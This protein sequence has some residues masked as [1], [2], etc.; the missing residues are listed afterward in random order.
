M[1]IHAAMEMPEDKPAYSVLYEQ[2]TWTWDE[3][4]S[5]HLEFYPNGRGRV[6]CSLHGHALPYALTYTKRP[7]GTGSTRTPSS[8]RLIGK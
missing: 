6:G 5:I 8:L 2:R 3:Y 4:K 7:G 1:D